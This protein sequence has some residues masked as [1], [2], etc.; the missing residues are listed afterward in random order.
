MSDATPRPDPD[1]PEEADNTAAL[2]TAEASSPAAP[3]PPAA[4]PT[5][6]ATGPAVTPPP[7]TAAAAPGPAAGHW[8]NRRFPLAVTAAALILGCVLGAG[9]VAVGAL[10]GDGLR[11]DDR[12]HNSRDER[13][14]GRDDNGGGPRFPGRGNRPNQ[15][16]GPVPANPNAPN[17]PSAAVPSPTTSS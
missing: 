8:W 15:N 6:A 13:F 2:P 4:E 9:V 17:A 7:F 14:R 5:A 3:L 11:G 12:G 16:N 1:K 10:V